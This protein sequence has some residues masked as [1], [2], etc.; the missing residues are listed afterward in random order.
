MSKK[1]FSNGTLEPW[2]PYRP[3]AALVKSFL[4]GCRRS[5]PKP[6][7]STAGWTNP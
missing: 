7:T 1:T 3:Q 6:A 5:L 4:G 2:Q